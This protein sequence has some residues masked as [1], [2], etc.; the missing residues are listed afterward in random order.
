MR[1]IFLLT[2]LFLLI[3][4]GSA[5]AA[6]LVPCGPGTGK[7]SCEFCDFFVLFNTIVKEVIF[8]YVPIVAVLMLVVGGVMFFLAGAKADAVNKAKGVITSV[9]V[10]LLIIFAA[11]V[12]VNTVL[13]KSGIV[14]SRSPFTWYQISCKAQ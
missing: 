4:S 14:E 2:F 13:T 8:K 9:I 3:S 12:I 6:G 11:W 5:Q 1:K 7:E 10:G